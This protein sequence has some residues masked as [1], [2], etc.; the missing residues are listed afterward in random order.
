M[1]LSQYAKDV[2]SQRDI[3]LEWINDTLQ[4]PSVRIE[5]SPDEF[6]FYKTIDE[7]DARCLKVVF[8]PIKKLIITVYFDRGMRKKGCK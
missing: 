6:T 8:N 3:K 7:Y 5:V 2:I 4:N 1:K